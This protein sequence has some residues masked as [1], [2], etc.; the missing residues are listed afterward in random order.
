[1][2]QLSSKILVD[3]SESAGQTIPNYSGRITKGHYCIFHQISQRQM[4]YYFPFK[5]VVSLFSYLSSNQA[6]KYATFCLP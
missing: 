3:L 4:M 6:A 5:Y 1:M 2:W